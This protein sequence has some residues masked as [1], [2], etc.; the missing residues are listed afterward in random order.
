M[1]TEKSTVSYGR[2]DPSP[3]PKM[4]WSVWIGTGFGTGLCP[5]ASG[6]AGTVVGIPIA[7]ALWQVPT[8]F[9]WAISGTVA[10]Q[11]V[12]CMALA[13]LAVPVCSAAEHYFR[14]KDD[15][16]IVADE[17][18]TYPLTLIGLPAS[19]IMLLF[20]F[21]THRF[22][23][24]LKPPPA[25]NLQRITGG[26]GIVIDDVISSLYALVANH[27]IYWQFIA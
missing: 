9:S 12:V 17:F 24:I 18:A 15:G 26:G 14:R 19:P 22:F 6:T 27:L 10:F 21:V 5:F 3:I 20:A 23:D 16:R 2:K 1:S 11:I 13:L 4:T 7:W 8:A 25:R